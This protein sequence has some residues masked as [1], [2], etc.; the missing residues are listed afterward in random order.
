MSVTVDLVT[1][2]LD[3][4]FVHELEIPGT[5]SCMKV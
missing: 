2:S 3:L 1:E 4:L 5:F